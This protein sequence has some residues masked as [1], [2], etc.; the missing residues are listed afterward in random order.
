MQTLHDSKQCIVVGPSCCLGLNRIERI[1]CRNVQSHLKSVSKDPTWYRLGSEIKCS[2]CWSFAKCLRDF[3]WPE[4]LWSLQFCKVL[5]NWGHSVPWLL[6]KWRL[7]MLGYRGYL[8]RTQVQRSINCVL[9]K[10]WMCR[11]HQGN[12]MTDWYTIWWQADTKAQSKPTQSRQCEKHRFYS[13]H[14]FI[15]MKNPQALE[16]H[17]NIA[18]ASAGPQFFSHFPSQHTCHSSQNR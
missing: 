9:A 14:Q 7:M 12:L 6:A 8:C 4:K 13:S 10:D 15:A 2:R 1:W 16:I 3:I 11:W 5:S 18:F 17:Q